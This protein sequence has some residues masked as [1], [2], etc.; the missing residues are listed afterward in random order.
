MKVAIFTD[1]FYPEVNGVVTCIMNLCKNLKDKGY[2]FIIFAPRYPK[3]IGS[4][5]LFLGNNVKIVRSISIGLTTNKN[6]RFAF[7]NLFKHYFEFKRFNPDIVHIHTP[8]SIGV[9][10]LVYAKL[11]RKPIM[12]TYHTYLPDFLGYVSPAKLLRISKIISIFY[13]KLSDEYKTLH[14]EIKALKLI[15]NSFESLKI[16]KG[17]KKS[18]VKITWLFTRLIYDRCELITA[19]SKVMVKELKK[20]GLK[21]NVYYLTNGVETEM[22]RPKGDL[23]VPEKEIRLINVGRL[24]YEK[25][26]DDVIRALSILNKNNKSYVFRLEIAGAGPELKNLKKLSDSLGL[27]DYVHF[28]GWV[29]REYLPELYSKSHI[30]VTAS[31]IETQGIVVLEAMS[32]GLPVVGANKLALNELIINGYNGY[33]ARAGDAN[34]FAK[35]IFAIATNKKL[36]SDMKVNAENT[37]EEHKIENAMDNFAVSYNKV[38]DAHYSWKLKKRIEHE[39]KKIRKIL[40]A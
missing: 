14:R 26:V 35:K 13:P 30:F 9:M 10:G 4:N 7:P 25:H 33:R 24:G 11:N 6:S 17:I 40:N 34:D 15:G 36:Y 31:T 39:T 3:S 29:R 16:R 37:V 32:S 5:D 8:M 1:T 12:G 21:R 2:E 19:P 27:R 23:N 20:N 22:F 38:C 18:A 28:S